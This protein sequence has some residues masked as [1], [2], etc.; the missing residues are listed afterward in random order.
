VAWSTV[1]TL[2]VQTDRYNFP[3]QMA[4]NE[5]TV[6]DNRPEPTSVPFCAGAANTRPPTRKGQL[7]WLG[8][9]IRPRESTRDRILRTAAE[10]FAERGFHGTGVA[11]LGKA[12]G[13][14]R[15]ALCY[16]PAAGKSSIRPAETAPG[17]GV[18]PG[19]GRTRQRPRSG[20]KAAPAPGKHLVTV[21]AR[22]DEGTVVM[23]EM[24]GLTGDRAARLASTARRTP[25]ALHLRTRR[26]CGLGGVRELGGGP[27]HPRRPALDL[28]LV[29]PGTRA[30]CRGAGRAADRLVLHGQLS[31]E[32]AGHDRSPGSTAGIP[33][34]APAPS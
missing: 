18:G 24:P 28:P 25:G 5:R 23:R 7:R 19:S 2:R 27:G 4:R 26:R 20:R 33:G 34:V 15:G 11:G 32:A 29:R 13:V 6:P 1:R 30:R 12:A 10:L 22:R 31:A 3:A 17:E 14:T 21:A 9:A 8:Q 16:H